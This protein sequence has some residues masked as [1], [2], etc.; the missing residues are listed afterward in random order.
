MNKTCRYCIHNKANLCEKLNDNLL[1]MAR[2]ENMPN[3]ELIISKRLIIKDK[4]IDTFSCKYF[5]EKNND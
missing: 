2:V 1:L 3:D 5:R 4:A